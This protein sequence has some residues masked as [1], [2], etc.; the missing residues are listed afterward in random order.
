MLPFPIV[1]PDWILTVQITRR[2][3]TQPGALHSLLDM[4]SNDRLQIS[5]DPCDVQQHVRFRTQLPFNL[6]FLNW[7]VA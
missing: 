5:V 6:R 2:I 4:E 1:R 7:F 3:A